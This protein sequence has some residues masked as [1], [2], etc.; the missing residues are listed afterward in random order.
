MSKHSRNYRSA[1]QAPEVKD[2]A[3][4]KAAIV[5]AKS[6]DWLEDIRAT[7]MADETLTS[8][9]K[10]LL[11]QEVA[12]RKVAL[13]AINKAKRFWARHAGGA[14]IVALCSFG[15]SAHAAIPQ[16]QAVAAII[17]EAGGESYATQLAV[18][19]AIRNRGTLQGVYG[20][21]N[22]VV[23]KASAKTI[24]RA[25]RAWLES[26]RHDVVRGCR[27]FGCKADA[28]KLIAFGLHAVCMS[29]AIT[30]YRA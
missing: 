30:F 28:P 16:A 17:G 27:F 9:E 6:F 21:N 7:A 3:F 5:T 12:E 8:D 2:C 29:G 15:F 26:A 22:P 18:A 4:Y 11:A 1:F 14:L 10:E 13:K 20:V 25:R 19:C 24:A 23:A